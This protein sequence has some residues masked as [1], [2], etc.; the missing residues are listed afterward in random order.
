[1][2]IE[3]LI[4]DRWLNKI[5]IDN[6][7][8]HI[9]YIRS[10][11]VWRDLPR[12]GSCPLYNDYNESEMRY[13]LKYDPIISKCGNDVF[14]YGYLRR[15]SDSNIYIPFD[16]VS[17]ITLFCGVIS[18]LLPYKINEYSDFGQYYFSR[19]EASVIRNIYGAWETMKNLYYRKHDT[20]WHSNHTAEIYLCAPLIPQKINKSTKSVPFNEL[21]PILKI[22]KKKGYNKINW[23]GWTRD[24]R[25]HNKQ[26]F[27]ERRLQGSRYVCPISKQIMRN[28]ATRYKNSDKNLY[29]YEQQ[30]YEADVL[31]YYQNRFGEF[32]GYLPTIDGVTQGRCNNAYVYGVNIDEDLKKEI[33]KFKRKYEMGKEDFS[34]AFRRR[35]SDY[36]GLKGRFDP[37]TKI[38]KYCKSRDPKRVL[39]RKWSA[40]SKLVDY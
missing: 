30:R 23:K 15:N 21:I 19:N 39:R 3:P 26:Y 16:I 34:L 10:Y 13:L 18:S 35:L 40:Y 14:V 11:Y 4:K 5:D 36:R 31:K 2:D 7:D 20:Y 28:P 9:V 1:M 37:S 6:L 17:I 25:Y 38:L 22:S 33:E 12:I 24:N 8:K 29:T 32:G 27:L